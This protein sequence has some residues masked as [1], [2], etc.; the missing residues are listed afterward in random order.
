MDPYGGPHFQ[1]VTAARR[2]WLES[3]WL[4]DQGFAV[5]VADGRGTPGRGRAGL[6]SRPR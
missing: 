5:I 1:R 4:A 3:Q 6:A 2:G